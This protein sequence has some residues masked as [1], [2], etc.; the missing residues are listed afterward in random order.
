MSTISKLATSQYLTDKHWPYRDPSQIKYIIPHYM[1][2]SGSTGAACA[3]YFVNNG[4]ENSA[5]YCIGVGGDISCN[6]VEDFGAWTSS[7]SLADKYAITIEVSNR[8]YGDPTIPEAAQ[9]AL[10]KLM[11][12]LIQRY[13]SLGGKA[14]Y[15]PTDEAEVVAARRAY[16][17]INAKGNILI[18]KW[19]GA[20]GTDCPGSHMIKILPEIC[21]EVNRRLAG[22]DTPT[23]K[24]TLF[25]EAQKMIDNGINGQ[26]RIN[27]AK[28]DGFDPIKV[29]AQI[30]LMLAKDKAAGLKSIV[31]ALPAVRSGSIGDAVKIVQTELKRMGYYTGTIDGEA[32]SAT[33]GAITAWQKNQNKVYG[34]FSVDGSWG[35]QCW[36]KYIYG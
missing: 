18:H 21:A 4:L 25:A 24:V 27:Q 36:N 7:F 1:A 20:Y 13:P 23:P 35:P 19:T 12:D 31:A 2:G 16:R 10:I 14:V 34:S 6:V 26:A 15:D 33:V 32:G 29:Q 5:N 3:K 17:T 11:V 28:A 22:G 30:D 9:E 8:A